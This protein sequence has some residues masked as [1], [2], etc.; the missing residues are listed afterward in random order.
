[1]E[2]FRVANKRE[3]MAIMLVCR[4]TCHWRSGPM[5]VNNQG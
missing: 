3:R 4:I 5:Y 2:S 1:M